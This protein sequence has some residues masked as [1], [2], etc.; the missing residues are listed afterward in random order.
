M[1]KKQS[2]DEVQF[3]QACENGNLKKVQAIL[4]NKDKNFDIN[5]RQSLGFR[6][7]CSYGRL[8]IVKYLLTSNE[9][10]KH[11]DMHANNDI[12]FRMACGNGHL[13]VVKY[14][15]ESEDL[16]DHPDVRAEEDTGLT[17][18]CSS[19][20]DSVV[21][22]LIEELDVYNTRNI[23]DII[24]NIMSTIS[25]K[26]IM[27]MAKNKETRNGIADTVKKAIESKNHQG[28]KK[29]TRI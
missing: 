18:A 6:L 3:F 29:M 13:D 22:Y 15:C 20:W 23:R 11:A 16:K 1:N 9:L 7:A 21:S 8:N 26:D 2:S 14:L 4:C 19:G 25:E 17:W 10:T 12:G 24:F 27:D 28:S 5:A